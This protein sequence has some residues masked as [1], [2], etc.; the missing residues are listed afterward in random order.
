MKIRNYFLIFFLVLILGIFFVKTIFAQTNIER[1]HDASILVGDVNNDISVDISDAAYL[2]NYLFQGGF[3]PDCFEKAD[4]NNDNRLDVSD[5]VFLLSYLFTGGEPPPGM[6]EEGINDN[7]QPAFVFAIDEEYLDNPA[8][9]EEI[10][11]VVPNHLT[12]LE[13]SDDRPDIVSVKAYKQRFGS[14]QRDIF[15]ETEWPEDYTEGDFKDIPIL[16]P[17]EPS[18]FIEGQSYVVDIV[19]EDKEGLSDEIS[20]IVHVDFQDTSGDR[21]NVPCYW[22]DDWSDQCCFNPSSGSYACYPDPDEEGPL[23]APACGSSGLPADAQERDAQSIEE[24]C[25]AEDC[26]LGNSETGGGGDDEKECTVE[27]MTILKKDDE[28]PTGFLIP[29]KFIFPTYPSWGVDNKKLGHNE[30][31]VYMLPNSKEFIGYS[32]VYRFMPAAIVRGNPSEC[33][34]YQFVQR[35]GTYLEPVVSVGDVE[36]KK[37]LAIP[38]YMIEKQNLLN[39]IRLIELKESGQLLS[40]TQIHSKARPIRKNF[41]EGQ[42]SPETCGTESTIYCQDNFMSE[43]GS[44]GEVS[45]KWKFHGKKYFVSEPQIVFIDQ[46]G[47]STRQDLVSNAANTKKPWT[48][49]TYHVFERIVKE[50]RYNFITIIEDSNGLF[51]WRCMVD[52]LKITNRVSQPNPNL[53]GIN[54]RKFDVTEPTC[55]CFREEFINQWE[56]V[57]DPDT[58]EE[59]KNNCG[60]I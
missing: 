24:C 53:A 56:I 49:P 55:E 26:Y 39:N 8:I 42:F 35:T 57:R 3:E 9:T 16:V 46:P 28:V 52:G 7:P 54:S 50:R 47:G 18:Y 40:L 17:L 58:G 1:C 37:S 4:I 45:E 34:E 12:I 5:V 51:R 33:S 13:L 21:G 2:L 38:G 6:Y 10:T 27:K 59:V 31:W 23:A 48:R 15:F 11:V 29:T 43:M 14:S 32:S 60:P 19:F 22:N 44:P 25:A 36:R 20:V 41:M 30:G